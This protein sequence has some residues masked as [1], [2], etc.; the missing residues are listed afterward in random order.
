MLF[1]HTSGINMSSKIFKYFNITPNLSLKSDWVNRSF[2]SYIDSSG[3][4]KKE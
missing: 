4:K 1:P 2:S 3:Q